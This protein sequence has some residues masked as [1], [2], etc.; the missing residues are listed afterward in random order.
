MCNPKIIE[1]IDKGEAIIFTKLRF[2]LTLFVIFATVISS[3]ALMKYKIDENSRKIDKFH[4]K[5]KGID[6]IRYNLKSLCEKS[7]V[8]YIEITK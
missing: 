5:I 7:G 3:F 2:Y 1:K 6:E 8:K 4:E